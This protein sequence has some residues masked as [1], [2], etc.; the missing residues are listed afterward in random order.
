MPKKYSSELSEAQARLRKEE[1]RR[2]KA[3]NKKA[4]RLR[5]FGPVNPYKADKKR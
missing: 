1:Q 4:A 3:E 2:R 5:Q